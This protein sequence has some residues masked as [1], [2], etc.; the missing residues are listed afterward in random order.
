MTVGLQV[1]PIR[2][3]VN[4]N[5]LLWKVN[6]CIWP[7]SC[8]WVL[9]TCIVSVCLSNAVQRL[10]KKTY[11]YLKRYTTLVLLVLI[12][13]MVIYVCAQN[14]QMY[15][16]KYFKRIYII[17]VNGIFKMMFCNLCEGIRMLDRAQSCRTDQRVRRSITPSQAWPLEY[18]VL[19]SN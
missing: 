14:Y 1:R 10:G 16:H 19:I 2:T 4:V 17:I 18:E 5:I 6:T 3:S 9:I 15:V 13:T 7:M 12:H 11:S 8:T